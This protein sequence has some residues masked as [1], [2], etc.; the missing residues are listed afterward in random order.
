M[1]SLHILTFVTSLLSI[2]F[3]THLK[4]GD[5][6]F[7]FTLPSCLWIVFDFFFD[8]VTQECVVQFQRTVI[9]L[10][11]LISGVSHSGQKNVWCNSSLLNLFCVTNMESTLGNALWYVLEMNMCSTLWWNAL[12]MLVRSILLFM[13][14]LSV[15]VYV[16]GLKFISEISFSICSSPSS[17]LLHMLDSLMLGVLNKIKSVFPFPVLLLE[18]RPWD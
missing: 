6:C 5:I 2:E 12:D 1:S 7:C 10:T 16:S 15:L 3:A 9:F 17:L 11:L 14:P 8:S 18:W 4:F 13:S